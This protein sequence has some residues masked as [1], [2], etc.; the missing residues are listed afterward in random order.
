MNCRTCYGTGIFEAEGFKRFECALCH[1]LGRVADLE[2]EKA[3]K[4]LLYELT[5][6][7]NF[8]RENLN[9]RRG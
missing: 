4:Q 6:R 7:N 5:K 2:A 1:G 8:S 9:K 3:E